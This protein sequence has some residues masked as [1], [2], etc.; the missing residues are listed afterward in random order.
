MRA[1]IL[2]AGGMLGHD[3]VRASLRDIKLSP[4]SKADLDV[5][6]TAA[7]ETLIEHLKPGVILNAAAYTA[8]DRA[9]AERERAF[10]VNAEAV[11]ELGRIAARVGAPVVH[12][13]TDYVF[14]GTANRP[15]REDSPTTPVNAYGESKLGGER[16]LAQSGAE[17][18]IVRT[19][20]LFGLNGRSFPRTMW[21][22]AR[23][24]VATRVV[25]DQTGR[26]TYSSDLASAVWTLIARGARGVIHVANDG[27]TTWFD[28]AAR[29]FARARRPEL[30][31]ACGTADFPTAA[32]RPT[33]SVL[34]TTRS[35]R[36]LAAPLPPWTD[37]IDR[38]LE[39]LSPDG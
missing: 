25:R 20:W 38:F 28:V 6:D 33:D 9:E 32:R 21:E 7:V 24:G 23:A 17:W 30:L 10:R 27:Q 5:T 35:E 16:A 36:E 14:D 19:Q 13:S 39:T 37:A 3:L 4:L 2:G 34:D 22:R 29:V 12:F 1:L 31:T 18:L 8:V 11:G 26:P 15:Y